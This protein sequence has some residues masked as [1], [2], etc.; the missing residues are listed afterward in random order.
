MAATDEL[1]ILS[2]QTFTIANG[3]TV[4]DA[5]RIVRS[6]SS[7]QW[8]WLKTTLVSLQMPTAWTAADITFQGSLDDTNYYP[9]YKLD[10]TAYKATGPVA[11]SIVLFPAIDLAG[12]PFLKLVSSVAQG[13]ARVLIA[14]LRYVT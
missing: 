4:S 13:G 1:P 8:P 11:S 5:K 9:L 6:Q 7:L 2:Q 14:S 3:Q 10:G 12:V